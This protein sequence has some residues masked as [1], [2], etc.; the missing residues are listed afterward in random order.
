MTVEGN[1]QSTDERDIAAPLIGIVDT[2]L[3]AGQMAL[4]ECS[5]AFIIKDGQLWQTEASADQIGHGSRVCDIIK[6]LAPQSRIANAV[7][8]SRP[9]SG[10]G[11][12]VTTAMQ[13]ATAIDWLVA[14]GAD[15]INLS[16]GLT[17]D[18]PVLKAA[19]ENAVNRGV[20][21]C[22]SSPAQG[23]A[24]YPSAYEGVI[25]ATGDARCDH[26]QISFLNSA[27]AD[28]AGCVRP[29]NGA[30]GA[31]GASMG[32]AHISGHIAGYLLKNPD[33]ANVNILHWL[34]ARADWHGREFRQAT[35][36]AEEES[37][38]G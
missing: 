10:E 28:V 13:V 1:Q 15:V 11:A 5:A 9:E 7:V 2:G 4:A 17:T 29:L 38:H 25:R 27:Q 31:S 8:F 22:A 19:C 34:N 37:S 12:A 21:L 24:V 18:R 30:L 6:Y 35:L 32:C 23:Q 16:L 26:H 36:I 33:S 20:I 14:E 3:N